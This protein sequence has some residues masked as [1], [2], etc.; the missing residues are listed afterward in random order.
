MRQKLADDFYRRWQKEY[1]TT[2][3]SFHEVRQQQTSVKFRRGDVAL[4]QEEV[5]PR[6]VWKCAI[7]E[8]VIE[9]RDRRIRTVV[10]RTPKG[11]KSPGRSNWSSHWKL[12]R[13]GRM[14][15]NVF[16]LKITSTTG[17]EGVVYLGK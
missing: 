5:R 15:R 1:L 16:P 9:G 11:K 14:W 7:I 8:R 10:L 13:V 12:T 2:L 17:M 3:R 4:L 6:H